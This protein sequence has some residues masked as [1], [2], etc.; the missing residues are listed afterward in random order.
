MRR[1][2]QAIAD[3]SRTRERGLASGDDRTATD[4]RLSALQGEL[5]RTQRDLVRFQGRI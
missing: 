1:L 4:A 3:L 5:D 2:Q